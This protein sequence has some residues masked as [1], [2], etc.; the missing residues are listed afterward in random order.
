M[1]FTGGTS[2][3]AGALQ[4]L[5]LHESDKRAY[6]NFNALDQETIDSSVC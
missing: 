5:Q 4:C 3:S 2:D 6:V 1:V